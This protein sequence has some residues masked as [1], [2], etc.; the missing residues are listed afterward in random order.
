MER[1]RVAEAEHA[2]SDGP[3]L[4]KRAFDGRKQR[5]FLPLRL[6]NKR[7]YVA[8]AIRTAPPD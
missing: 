7:F 4:D 6:F 1:G 8:G 2:A 5:R 3:D